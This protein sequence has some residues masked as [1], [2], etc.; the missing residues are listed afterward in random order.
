M[1]SDSDRGIIEEVASRYGAA[2][3]LLFGSSARATGEGRDIDLAVEGIPPARFFEFYGELML[4]LS[5][6]V[7]VIDLGSDSAFTR[8]VAAEGVPISG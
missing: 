2:R 1:I 4:K 6:P 5:K 7:D 3:V 8:M